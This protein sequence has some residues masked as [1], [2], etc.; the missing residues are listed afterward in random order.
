[1]SERRRH[2]DRRQRGLR[3]VP[4]ELPAPP[5]EAPFLRPN[6]R[7]RVRRARRGWMGR[8]IL[9]LEATGGVLVVASALWVSYS[10]VMAS[11]RL[12]VDKVEVRG[13]H[14]LSEGEVRELLGPAVG[15]NILGLDIQALKGRLRSSPWVAEATVA[16][17]LPDTLRVEIRE[18]APLALAELDRLY[19]MDGDGSLI[20]VYGP[21]TAG[22]DLAAGGGVGGPAPRPA[23]G[24]R[25]GAHGS[26]ALA[27]S[28]PDVPRPAPGALGALPA[29]R[30]LRPALPR[31][32]RRE[33]AGGA[34]GRRHKGELRL[35]K[36]EEERPLRRRPRHRDP[37]NLRDRRGDHAPRPQAGLP[38]RPSGIQSRAGGNE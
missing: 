15:E 11:E 23:R 35:A 22:F 4:M 34:D 7:T 24:G 33:G 28:V 17:S 5:E 3:I 2:D 12:R 1:M 25:G 27:R 9:L 21:R 32:H 26:A 30:V 38:H 14:F 16:R 6:R 29:G 37:Q 31:P 8:S 10:R 13:S 36:K 20:D 19:L 18:R